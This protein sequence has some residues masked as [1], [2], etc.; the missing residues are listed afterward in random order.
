MNGAPYTLDDPA[1][2][3]LVKLLE[4]TLAQVRAGQLRTIAVT[5]VGLGGFGSAFAGADVAP[6]YMALDGAKAQIMTICTN[7]QARSPIIRP[8]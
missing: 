5:A 3:P 7:P 1:I 6:L 8:R 2:Q 4:D